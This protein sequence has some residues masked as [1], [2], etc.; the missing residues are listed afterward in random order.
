MGIGIIA[1]IYVPVLII[2]IVMVVINR[3][4]MYKHINTAKLERKVL[5]KLDSEGIAWK[6]ED[7]ELY[8]VKK[9]VR[10]DTYFRETLGRNTARVFFAYR[11][12]DEDL[13][14]IN[15]WGQLV[16]ADQLNEKY[17]ANTTIIRNDN[18]QSFCYADIRTAED[19]MV[20]F[21]NAYD[22]YANLMQDY[23]IMKPDIQKDFPEKTIQDNKKTIGFG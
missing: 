13:K 22:R 21:T 20:E 10:F 2:A 23:A 15:G 4:M 6:K 8:I 5:D 9:G 3:R 1:L 17:L 12:S 16:M 14:P 7:G 18:L 19:F 11:L